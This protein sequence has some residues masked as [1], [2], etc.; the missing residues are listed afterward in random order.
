MM[1]QNF[2]KQ[3]RDMVQMSLMNTHP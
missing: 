1:P 2:V 3:F